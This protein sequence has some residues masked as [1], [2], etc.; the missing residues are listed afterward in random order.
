MFWTSLRLKSRT[1]EIRD[2][3]PK[4]TPPI[5]LLFFHYQKIKPRAVHDEV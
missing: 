3:N 1:Y 4:K 5:L 2:K